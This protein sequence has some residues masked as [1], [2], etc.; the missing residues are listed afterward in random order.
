MNAYPA[1]RPMSVWLRSIAFVCAVASCGAQAADPPEPASI[2]PFPA[3]LVWKNVDRPLTAAELRGRAVLLD[4]FSP[5]CINCVHM[6]PVEAQLERHFGPRLAVIGIDTPKFDGSKSAAA[7]QDFIARHQLTHPIA[8]DSK[9][10]LWNAYGV[11]AW[12]TLVL[13]GPDGR[14]MRAFVGEQDEATLEAA[15]A[16]ALKDAPAIRNLAPL[17]RA[18]PAIATSLLA[19]PAGLAV[20]HRLVAIS[21]TGHNRILITSRTGTSLRIIGTGCAGH[22]DGT[23]DRARFDAPHGLAFHGSAL[24]VADTGNH[25]I[26][27]ID[28]KTWTTTTFAG[29]GQRAYVTSGYSKPLGAAL[30]SPWDLAWDGN[31]LYISMAGDHQIWRLDTLAGVV[32]PWAGTGAE[33]LRDGPRKIARFAQPSGLAMHDHTLYVADAESSSIRAIP[34]PD[35]RSSQDS[36]SPVTTLVGQGL[37]SFGLKDGTA[38]TAL[39]QH[40]EAVAWHGGTLYIADTF[41]DAIRALDLATQRISTVA[42]VARPLALRATGDGTLLV[43]SRDGLEALDIRHATVRPWRVHGLPPFATACHTGPA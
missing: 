40:D 35:G 33:G 1:F 39:L 11:F 29:N 2:E 19:T 20:S 34:L 18:L 3:G 24:Y 16:S 13:I 4:F 25:L 6:L 7:L 23:P 5:G 31:Q 15:I 8:L 43:T 32:G 37:F 38:A 30:D 12:P 17:P 27:R 28:L 14:L 26:R 42:H 10:Q 21:D 36:E 9:A 22:A 41:N